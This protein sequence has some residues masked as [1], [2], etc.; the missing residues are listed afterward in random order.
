L[1]T[2][3]QKQFPPDHDLH[4]LFGL[5]PRSDK[6]EIET[7]WNDKNLASLQ[8]SVINAP[9][10]FDRAMLPTTLNQALK[11]A[12]NAFKEWRYRV[13]GHLSFM[14]MSFPTDVRDAIIRIHPDWRD[15]P[16]DAGGFQ[17][18]DRVR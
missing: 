7:V 15:D 5:L 16:P 13:K 12:A 17:S 11:I 2:I 6:E 9:P 8:Q 14:L 10:S 4:L 18:K 1:L 3:R